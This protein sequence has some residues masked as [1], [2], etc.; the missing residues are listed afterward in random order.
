ME[1]T[2]TPLYFCLDIET[3]GPIPGRHSILSIGVVQVDRE[4]P[5]R[6]NPQV[7][8]WISTGIWYKRLT[9]ADGAERHPD[10]I[11]WWTRNYAS[12]MQFNALEN[13]NAHGEPPRETPRQ[14]IISLADWI[15]KAV[16]D[17]QK[18]SACPIVPVCVCKPTVF[19]ATFLHWYFV[20]YLDQEGQDP[21]DA[22]PFE[23][24]YIDVGSFVAGYLKRPYPVPR[25]AWPNDW[26]TKLE[27]TH[28]ALDDAL[29]LADVWSKILND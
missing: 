26:R 11:R 18:E 23:F 20:R 24:R 3:D 8:T 16:F 21:K 12:R 14:A 27:S 1:T 7:K 25:S 6:D 5:P 28:H 9:P 22:D 10:T 4:G 2:K 19:D 13:P 29:A 17:A 15:R